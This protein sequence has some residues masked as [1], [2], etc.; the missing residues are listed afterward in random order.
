M[1]RKKALKSMYS[2]ARPKAGGGKGKIEVHILVWNH[3]STPRNK[4][5]LN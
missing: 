2:H 1:Q 5:D 4:V 3:I